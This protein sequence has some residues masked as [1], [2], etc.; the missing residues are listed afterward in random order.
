VDGKEFVCSPHTFDFPHSRRG[1][2]QGGVV[3]IGSAALN[4]S[5]LLFPKGWPCSLFLSRGCAKSHCESRHLFDGTS[6]YPYIDAN[7]DPFPLAVRAGLGVS[8]EGFHTASQKKRKQA[9]FTPT[10]FYNIDENHWL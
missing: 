6:R 1:I 2:P 5:L 8:H 7:C 4:F 10:E 3:D 9:H